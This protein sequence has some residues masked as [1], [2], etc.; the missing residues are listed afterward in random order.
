MAAEVDDAGRSMHIDEFLNTEE[1]FCQTLKTL[2]EVFF[3]FSFGWHPQPLWNSKFPYVFLFLFFFLCSSKK[4]KDKFV[5]YAMVSRFSIF[6]QMVIE[7]LTCDKRVRH[8]V[9][10]IFGNFKILLGKHMVFLLRFREALQNP[11]ANISEVFKQLF[12]WFLMTFIVDGRAKSFKF[13]NLDL[14]TF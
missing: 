3:V 8:E 12:Q 9:D 13:K 11:S 5:A 2:Q 7:P 4:K 1:A 14:N 10:S 6:F